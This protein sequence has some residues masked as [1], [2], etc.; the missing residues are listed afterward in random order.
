MQI[1]NGKVARER[2][3]KQETAIHQNR[4]IDN[5]EKRFDLIF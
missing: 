1:R 5:K 4:L 2:F 3:L